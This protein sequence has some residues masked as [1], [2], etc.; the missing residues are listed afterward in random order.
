M[1]NELNA[2]SQIQDAIAND[3][4]LIAYFYSDNCAPCIS[5][6]P[7][8]KELLANDYPKMNLYF[9]NSEKFPK[10]PAEFGIFSSPT[11]LV[12]FDR[13]EYLRK[14]KYISI[15]ELSQGIER[16]YNMMFED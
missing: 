7:K 5:L 2:L 16:L 12:Y 4:G 14:S 6:R 8:V 13:K 10:I 3:G 15:P 11:L 9:I 1:D